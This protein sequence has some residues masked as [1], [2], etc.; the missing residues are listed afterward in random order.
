[1]FFNYNNNTPVHRQRPLI[2]CRPNILI[3]VQLSIN[4]S[5]YKIA[6]IGQSL[7]VRYC[8]TYITYLNHQNNPIGQILMRFPI[9]L[10]QGS[11]AS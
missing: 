6:F 5:L 7:Y 11:E 9:L 8:C 1:M 4:K 2:F 10:R 3:L